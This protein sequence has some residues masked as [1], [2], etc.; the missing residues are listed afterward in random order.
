MFGAIGW[1]TCEWCLLIVEQ[2]TCNAVQGS[3]LMGRITAFN[4]TLFFTAIFGL[5]ASCANS[6]FMLGVM[7]FFLGSAVGVRT[8][9]HRHVD[10]LTV[11]LGF[12][13]HRRDTAIG[14]HAKI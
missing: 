8:S 12:N 3:D 1:G 10:E 5:L 7:L 11:L 14:T 6:F 4:A 13:A 9:L 2:I